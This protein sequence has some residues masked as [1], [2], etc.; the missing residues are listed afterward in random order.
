MALA[1]RR[2]LVLAA[3]GW[4]TD[5]EAAPR[6]PSCL[7]NGS[8]GRGYLFFRLFPL[9]LSFALWVLASPP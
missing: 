3:R 6:S 7:E 4:G 1:D 2:R 9:I 8:P 5:Q